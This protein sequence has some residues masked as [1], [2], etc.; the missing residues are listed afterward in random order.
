MVRFWQSVDGDE[1]V[2][3]LASERLRV[4]RPWVLIK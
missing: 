2:R 3:G 4:T 1:T